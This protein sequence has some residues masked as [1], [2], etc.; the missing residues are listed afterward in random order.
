[1]ITTKKTDKSSSKSTTSDKTTP[2]GKALEKNTQPVKT[3][4][5]PSTAATKSSPIKST[6]NNTGITKDNITG[7]D[8]KLA[9]GSQRPL[10]AAKNKIAQS[11]IGNKQRPN[12]TQVAIRRVPKIPFQNITLESSHFSLEKS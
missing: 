2:K 11:S 8:P 3:P 5:R 12:E 7:K 9:Q 6:L 1:M 4:Q 10:T